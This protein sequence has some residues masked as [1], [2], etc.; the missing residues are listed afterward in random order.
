MRPIQRRRVI[1]RGRAA[2]EQKSR[3]LERPVYT[4]RRLYKPRA[5][6]SGEPLGLNTVT[7]RPWRRAGLPLDD[8]PGGPRQA[9]TLAAEAGWRRVR[10]S[11][12]RVRLF[13][14]P[15]AHDEPAAVARTTRATTLGPAPTP[16]RAP[17]TAVP[18][19]RTTPIAN[20]NRRTTRRALT[21][22]ARRDPGK[23]SRPGAGRGLGG[24]R[25]QNV[26]GGEFCSV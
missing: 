19:A 22:G 12:D 7:L 5:T 8:P 14:W 17:H 4:R 18:G 9:Q 6:A 1:L 15:T 20:K 13:L 26:Q 3:N 23:G 16:R 10:R 25:G 2:R 21:T 11:L 24:G